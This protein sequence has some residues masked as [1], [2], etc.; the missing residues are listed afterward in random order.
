MDRVLRA[1]IVLA[2]VSAGCQQF[3]GFVQIDPPPSDAYVSPA[4]WIQ[5][6]TTVDHSCGIRPDNTLWCW[7]RNGHGELGAGTALEIDSPAQVGSDHYLSVAVNEAYTCAV[8]SDHIAS[9]WGDNSHGELGTGGITAVSGANPLP[10]TWSAVACGPTS[11][12][13][14]TTAGEVWCW[15][16]ASYG[17]LGNN[18]SGAT[19]DGPVKVLDGAHG[20]TVGDSFACALDQ[21]G[22]GWCWGLNDDGQQLGTG[23]TKVPTMVPTAD[24][25]TRI[26]A[27][28]KSVCGLLA[29]GHLRCWGDNSSGQ[30][31]NGNTSSVTAPAHVSNDAIT[32]WTNVAVGKHHACALRANGA[33][34]CWGSNRH[35]QLAT[36]PANEIETTPIMVGVATWS[37]VFAG[38]DQTCLA[39]AADLVSCAGRT[40]FGQLATTGSHTVPAQESTHSMWT[41]TDAGSIS[42]C[43]IDSANTLKCWGNNQDGNVGDNS[44]LDQQAP[45]LVPVQGSA[46]GWLQVAVG[47]D[48]CALDDLHQ[49]YCWGV[50][51]DAEVGNGGIT[52]GGVDKPYGVAPGRQFDTTTTTVHTCAIASGTIYCWGR[53]S[54]HEVNSTATA[55]ITDPNTSIFSSYLDI[56][57]G[58]A[59]TCA[60]A[61]DQSVWCWGYNG[62]G[63][64]GVNDTNDRMNPTQV[65]ANGQP[66]LDR[67]FA[68]THTSCGL[69]ITTGELWCWGDNEQGQLGDMTTTI[70]PV[71]T[72]IPGAW[73]EIGLGG[74]FT[75][76]IH[77]DHTLWCTGA[78]DYGQLGQGMVGAEST[79]FLQVGA[80]NDWVHIGAGED[81]VCAIKTDASLWCWGRNDDGELG[82][83]TAWSYTLVPL[84]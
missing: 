49:L 23:D 37:M 19:V 4:G 9:C 68:G 43:A 7:G 39:D 35:S 79:K 66:K 60:L 52:V 13:G 15:G 44:S 38:Y 73:L 33:A 21:D 11:A 36:M 81:H 46:G 40:G 75:C 58:V 65:T 63:D 14:L 10:N 6:A 84:P 17:Q 71:P 62:E 77:A 34:Y 82:D 8:R 3:L 69:V 70:R 64:L 42:T 61:G 50:D 53:N 76:G 32:D 45:Q 59:H 83:G 12:C 5:I 80:A 25:F 16:T 78:N 2:L 51:D 31:G 24:R 48:V 47:D 74:A 18:D 1:G 30:L 72:H 55:P 29:D 67:V 28:D 54:N 26:A 57:A 20:L 41:A 56:A 27:G 22:A